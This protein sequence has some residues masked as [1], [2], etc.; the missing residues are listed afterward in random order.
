M[1]MSPVQMFTSGVHM[2][3][4]GYIVYYGYCALD[5]GDIVTG[6]IGYW[7]GYSIWIFYPLSPQ[8]P[9]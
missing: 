1:L 6:S 4:E 5:A 8:Y 2:F 7:G 9:I 3:K